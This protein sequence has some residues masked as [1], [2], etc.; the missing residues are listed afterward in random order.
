LLPHYPPRYALQF[1][2]PLPPT[3]RPTICCPITPHVTPY[4]T[5]TKNAIRVIKSRMRWAGHVAHMRDRRGA[6][7]ILLGK[8]DEKNPRGRHRDG[9]IILKWNFKK[10]N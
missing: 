5:T 6:Y 1:A 7:S 2:A 4:G 10:R 3:L 8:P 9:R